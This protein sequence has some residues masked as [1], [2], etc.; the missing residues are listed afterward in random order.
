[1]KY[2]PFVCLK[3]SSD[4]PRYVYTPKKERHSDLLNV[5]NL[6]ARNQMNASFEGEEVKV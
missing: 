2:G 1:M 4:C 6:Y 3:I 5:V